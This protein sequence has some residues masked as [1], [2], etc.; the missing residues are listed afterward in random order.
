MFRQDG[1]PG[2]LS[3]GA[4]RHAGRAVDLQAGHIHTYIHTYM[5]ILNIT[6]THTYTYAYIA[7]IN[8]KMP[9][10]NLCT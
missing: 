2:S 8:V 7:Y 1:S 6:N 9:T 5:C 3:N 4:S 10:K